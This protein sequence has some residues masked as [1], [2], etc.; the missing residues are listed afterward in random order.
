MVVSKL[1]RPMNGNEEMKTKYNFKTMF[2]TFSEI[3]IFLLLM[4][5]VC[6]FRWLKRSEEGIRSLELESQAVTSHLIWA[7]EAKLGF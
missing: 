4:V 5:H 6:V 2:K 1:S 3:F 7:L